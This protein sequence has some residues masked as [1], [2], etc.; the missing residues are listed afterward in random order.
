MICHIFI[1][2]S[3]DTSID[4]P[5]EVEESAVRRKMPAHEEEWLIDHLK[6][7][8][9]EHLIPALRAL[10]LKNGQFTLFVDR[11]WPNTKMEIKIRRLKHILAL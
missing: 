11:K 1:Y 4:L 2:I 7:Q 3:E 8:E 9:C 10:Y 6:Q 5:F